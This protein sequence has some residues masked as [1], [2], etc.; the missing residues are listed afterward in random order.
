MAASLLFCMMHTLASG[1]YQAWSRA[2]GLQLPR[3]S[4]AQPAARIRAPPWPGLWPDAWRDRGPGPL[5]P[6]AA[7]RRDCGGDHPRGDNAGGYRGGC[8]PRGPPVRF[9]PLPPC[10]PPTPGPPCAPPE[11]PDPLPA[12]GHPR[13]GLPLARPALLSSPALPAPLQPRPP[14][15][16]PHPARSRRP[17]A[18]PPHP[19]PVIPSA[20]TPTCTASMWCTRSTAA[21]SPSSATQSLWTCRLAR[22]GRLWQQGWAFPGPPERQACLPPPAR[23]ARPW[24]RPSPVTR[25]PPT[26]FPTRL[27][28]T[29]HPPHLS[30]SPSHPLPPSLPTRHPPHLPTRSHLPT[31]RRGEDHPRPR[32]QRLH[33]RQA[34]QPGVYQRV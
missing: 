12:S 31:C 17:A 28:P 34:A 14:P 21:A 8:A 16:P 3:F 26:R 30:A 15:T 6:L 13:G 11:P 7:C 27:G 1:W 5:L 19:H 2:V 29:P 18:G 10:A 20:A 23:H 24:A 4:A 9:P 32:P 25:T 33:D 22:V